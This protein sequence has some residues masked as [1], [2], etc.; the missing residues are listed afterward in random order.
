MA[1]GLAARRR[2][3]GSRPPGP[4]RLWAGRGL[5]AVGVAWPAWQVAQ[6]VRDLMALRE[7]AAEA[8]AP[9]PALGALGTA[10]IAAPGP[11]IFGLLLI[12]AGLLVRGRGAAA[13]PLGPGGRSGVAGPP[14]TL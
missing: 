14:P 3:E 8:G 2:R 5:I 7:S 13:P 1:A 11:L 12:C 4:V 10:L 9:P 6:A